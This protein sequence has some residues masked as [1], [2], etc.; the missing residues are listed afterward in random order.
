VEKPKSGEPVLKA[1]VQVDEKATK[2][3]YFISTGWKEEKVEQSG[4][5]VEVA[6]PPNT[7][8]EIIQQ[9]ETIRSNIVEKGLP[10]LSCP[11]SSNLE[12][13]VIFNGL[14]K[15]K[16]KLRVGVEPMGGKL[17][18]VAREID[19]G[20][21]VVPRSLYAKENGEVVGYAIAPSIQRFTQVLVENQDPEWLGR[22]K[23][24]KE[25]RVPMSVG[26][27]NDR[28][29][30]KEPQMYFYS[31]DRDTAVVD[32]WVHTLAVAAS[33]LHFGD[34]ASRFLLP[35]AE[36]YGGFV[37]KKE[38]VD[39]ESWFQ[40]MMDKGRIRLGG[41]VVDTEA[42]RRKIKSAYSGVSG[43]DEYLPGFAKAFYSIPDSKYV[44][45]NTNKDGQTRA[46]Y[47][48]QTRESNIPVSTLSRNIVGDI[49]VSAV[50]FIAHETIHH[51]QNAEFDN[52]KEPIAYLVSYLIR[53]TYGVNGDVPLDHL[54]TGVYCKFND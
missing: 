3:L 48:H 21:L 31:C 30:N 15:T 2:G 53:L 37:H 1:V 6:L 11:E 38:K 45:Y 10:V 7:S 14:N 52:G 26:Y 39:F 17:V 42:I 36:G 34:P 54:Q 27:T 4:P 35:R 41:G 29:S 51:L 23:P 24:V 43:V 49:P 5:I 8:A 9:A 12:T 19:T 47:S 20:N 32:P 28:S 40:L 44:F 22:M 25:K 13:D 16:I 46:F 50:D 33:R 18:A